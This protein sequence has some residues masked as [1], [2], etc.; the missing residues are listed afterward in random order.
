MSTADGI[1]VIPSITVEDTQ[2]ETI[3]TVI[4]NGQDIE[5]DV[6]IIL[7]DTVKNLNARFRF[8]CRLRRRAASRNGRRS[9]SFDDVDESTSCAERFWG[10]L[11]VI[12]TKL[13]CSKFIKSLNMVTVCDRVDEVSRKF[14]PIMFLLLNLVY[15]V[16]YIYIM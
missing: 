16:S 3:E 4:T 15:W 14:F 2:W 6:G 10:G 11:E 7:G 8:Q 1:A 5:K 9:E 12:L 13:K